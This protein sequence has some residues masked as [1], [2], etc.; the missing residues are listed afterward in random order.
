MNPTPGYFSNQIGPSSK[1]PETPQK[2]P[3]AA[4]RGLHLTRKLS[5]RIIA[6]LPTVGQKDKV[7]VCDEF[8]APGRYMIYCSGKL[9]QAVMAVR[10]Y[11]DSKTFVDKPIKEGR[12][13]S[14]I[15]SDFEKKFPQPVHQIP[16]ADVKK[17]VDENFDEEGYEL[18]SCKLADWVQY[19][20]KFKSIVD[21]NMRM[22][23]L[24]LNVIWKELCREVKP[25]VKDSPER[26]SLL[27]VPYP[28]VVPGGRFREFYYWD[29]YWI[30]K[31]LIASNLTDTA[32]SMI[33]NF[34]HIIDTYGF[35]PNGGRVYYLR[36]SQPPLF[37]PM[38][39]E[40]Y[41]ATRD[42]DLVREMLPI[43]EKEQAFWNR[44]RSLNIQLDG[45]NITVYQ[46]RT[47]STD[48]RPESYREDTFHAERLLDTN[49]KRQFYQDI[50]SAAESGW[51]FSTRWF[52]DNKSLTSIETTN[53]LPVD[54]NAFI[55][56]N[57]H[58]IGN[59]HGNQHKSSAWL[60]DYIKFRENF[61]KVF[62]VQK[63]KGWYDYNLRT[64]RHNTDFYASMAVPLF[65][66]CYEPLSIA[67]SDDLYSKMEE[68]GV[69]SY[70][71]GIPTSLIQGDQQWDFPN[72]WSPLN[73]MIVEGLRKS[74][75]P[76]MQQKAFVLAQKWLLGNLHVFEN[77]QAMW[78]KYDVVSS[79]PR[80]G[81]GGEYDVQ[82]GF[83]WT[84]G[85]ALDLLVSYG[86]RLVYTTADA[87]SDKSD[88]P[89]ALNYG[90]IAAFTMST[91][92]SSFMYLYVLL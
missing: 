83:G 49:R 42:K 82:P 85:A 22:F 34:A 18:Q 36:R 5:Q 43:M 80:L 48:F 79:E 68:M 21:N 16:R 28:F 2:D 92:I 63:A 30:V 59:L 91:V 11:N 55:C 15:L 17:F 29:A 57:M 24:K 32:K 61:G 46:Y 64:Q 50:A 86:D 88:H 90:S 81:S 13:G 76:R 35:I 75:D 58:I 72:G 6:H 41:Q 69:F 3:S 37:S 67:K 89:L 51:D 39:Y 8:N 65:T 40:Y 9:L 66:Q 70:K 23:A 73:H 77:D 31:G 84:N 25:E 7:E 53:I 14:Q 1:Q 54:L 26:F 56:Y 78:E 52:A 12:V 62:W 44:N 27:H 20:P 74:D 60:M 33:L 45:E 47:P 38:V 19:P 4:F 10:L 71:G 87:P